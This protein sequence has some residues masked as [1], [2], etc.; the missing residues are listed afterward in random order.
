MTVGRP[1]R[2][3]CTA[4]IRSFRV[5]MRRTTITVSACAMGERSSAVDTGTRRTRVSRRGRALRGK[6]TTVGVVRHEWLIRLPRLADSARACRGSVARDRGL[7]V[8]QRTPSPTSAERSGSPRTR[9]I[10]RPCPPRLRM[11]PGANRSRTREPERQ[12]ARRRS[13]P[14]GSGASAPYP[15]PRRA[16]PPAAS[17]PTARSTQVSKV[18]RFTSSGSCRWRRPSRKSVQAP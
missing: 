16:S 3:S 4:P 12:R 10:R 9:P 13:R 15:A 2:W 7:Q 17:A 14:M 18:A 11:D 6:T 1:T 5:A 8:R